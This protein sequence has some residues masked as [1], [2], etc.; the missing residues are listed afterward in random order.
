MRVMVFLARTES[1]SKC[2]KR[3]VAVQMQRP[4][5]EHVR[6]SEGHAELFPDER[7]S[8]ALTGRRGS[9]LVSCKDR[10]GREKPLWA[11]LG[12]N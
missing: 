1:Q 10:M 9:L 8:P 3:G 12:R 7:P 2:E 4:K 6:G 11:S 5:Q